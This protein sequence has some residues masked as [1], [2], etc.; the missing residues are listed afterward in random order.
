M[1]VHSCDGLS[2]RRFRIWCSLELFLFAFCCQ[3][4]RLFLHNFKL[5][6][7]YIQIIGPILIRCFRRVPPLVL[8]IML[9]TAYE[10]ILRYT[11]LD[12]TILDRIHPRTTFFLQN[13]DCVDIF[14]LKLHEFNRK[15]NLQHNKRRVSAVLLD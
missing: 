9:I 10:F 15:V 1:G 14:L 11:G 4:C 3:S 2:C 8:G 7:I 13:K 6:L 12:E 5:K